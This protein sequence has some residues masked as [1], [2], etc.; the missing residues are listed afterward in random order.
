MSLSCHSA[1]FS[2]LGMTALLMYLAMPV[3]FSLKIGLR[4]W[5]IAE[6]PF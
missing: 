2:I 3:K 6:D 5:G 4:L 1:I